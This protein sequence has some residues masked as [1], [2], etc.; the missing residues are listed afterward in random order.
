M[1]FF[2]SLKSLQT[3]VLHR[4][5]NGFVRWPFHRASHEDRQQTAIGLCVLV[6]VRLSLGHQESLKEIK[7]HTG[8]R[9]SRAPAVVL[10]VAL[11]RLTTLS[12]TVWRTGLMSKIHPPMF[13]SCSLCLLA[14]EWTKLFDWWRLLR[15]LQHRGWS[16]CRGIKCFDEQA[17]F[18]GETMHLEIYVF[19]AQPCLSFYSND[20]LNTISIN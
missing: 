6:C 13:S 19:G 3:Q 8:I 9:S 11:H 10:L 20:S 17:H 2:V 16:S 7:D 14:H 18:E 15:N 1:S 4:L 5:V 12:H